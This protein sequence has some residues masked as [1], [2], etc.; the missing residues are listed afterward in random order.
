MKRRFIRLLPLS[1]CISAACL[2]GT[3]RTGGATYALHGVFAP[4]NRSA[5][6][7]FV[8]TTPAELVGKPFTITVSWPEN[9]SDYSPDMNSSNDHW[10]QYWTQLILLDFNVPGLNFSSPQAPYTRQWETLND[11]VL[12]YGAGAPQVSG[13]ELRLETRASWS[14]T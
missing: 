3:S 13:D 6:S 11:S 1:I 10:G 12:S 7:E 5:T 14:Q 9:A 2:A 4:T 8:A